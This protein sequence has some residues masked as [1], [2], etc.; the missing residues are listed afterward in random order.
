MPSGVTLLNPSEP[1]YGIVRTLYV[2]FAIP[3]SSV[4]DSV[5]AVVRTLRR[6]EAD[7]LELALLSAFDRLASTCRRSGG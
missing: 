4:V 1:S 3:Y 7:A 6:R 2:W 5:A